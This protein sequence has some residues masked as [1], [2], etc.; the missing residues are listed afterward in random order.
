MS[1]PTKRSLNL[2][3]A[4]DIDG[5]ITADPQFFSNAA[6]RV[7]RDGGQVHIVT[8]RSEQ[9]RGDTIS[10][11]KGYKIP[12]SALHCLPSISAAQTL[13]P[14][15]QLDWYQRHQWLKIAYAL[16]EQITHF[17]DDDPKVCYVVKYF[18]MSG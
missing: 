11:L 3:L 13:C 18:Q 12:Y 5:T 14:H 8:S 10:E 2:R 1:D 4:L 17:V 16:N 9:G 7:L 6:T 15:K